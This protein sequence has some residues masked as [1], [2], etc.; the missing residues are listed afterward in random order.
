[1]N[2]I[3]DAY[4]NAGRDYNII[5]V[6]WKDAASDAL[7]LGSVGAIKVI[8]KFLA[9]VVNHMVAVHGA[10]AANIHIIG[11]SLGAHW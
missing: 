5:A 10:N 11:H 7:Y 6:D 4:F 3:R 2:N 1:M 9:H 8:G